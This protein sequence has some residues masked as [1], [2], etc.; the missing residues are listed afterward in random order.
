M[1][2]SEADRELGLSK[3]MAE[4]ITDRRH[5]GKIAHTVEEMIRERVYAISLGYEDANDL[6]TL[7]S[8][9]ALKLACG[10]LPSSPDLASPPTISRLENSVSRKDLYKMGMQIA[11][12]AVERLQPGTREVVL[13]VDVA[14]DP[15]HGQQE[16]RFF[17][18]YYDE[19]CYLP[20][21]AHITG[22]DEVGQGAGRN[23]QTPIAQ[24]R[25]TGGGDL[26]S[27]MASP[28]DIVPGKGDMEADAP[29]SCFRH[30]LTSCESSLETRR[31]S[32]RL[33]WRPKYACST[34]SQA[35]KRASVAI[36]DRRRRKRSISPG[37]RKGE[38]TQQTL[39]LPTPDRS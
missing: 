32:T 5:R 3:A 16:F 10:I 28:T 38:V 36:G 15:C 6:D 2:L 20:L 8:D 18:A 33:A 21:F 27:G 34:C 12:S 31:M 7:G 37:D 22:G 26:P 17:S 4:A 19:Y 39:P 23:T 25:R 13:E 30:D 29:S 14:D 11:R 9:P 35:G 1:L 24:S